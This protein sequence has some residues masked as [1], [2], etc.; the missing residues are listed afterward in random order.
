[1]TAPEEGRLSELFVRY[2]D[3]MLTGA[4]AEELG[5]HLAT[6]ASAREMFEMCCLHA[7]VAGEQPAVTSWA[8][9]PARKVT[10][11][12]AARGWSRRRVISA[13]GGS[14]AASLLAGFAGWRFWEAHSKKLVRLS[15]IVGDVSLHAANGSILPLTSLVPLGATVSTLGPVSSVV[16]SYSDG[17]GISLTGDS[18]LTVAD[19]SGQLM[20]RRGG[21][22]A[23]IASRPADAVPITVT[24]TEA[25]VGE[26]NGVRLSMGRIGNATVVS[27]QQGQVNVSAASGESLGKVSG[28]ELLTVRAHGACRKEPMPVTPDQ[29]AWTLSKPLPKDWALG[30]RMESADG[31]F[32]VPEYWFDPYH[33]ARMCQIRSDNQWNRGL[34]RVFPDSI[35]RVRYWVDR[36]APSQVSIVVR[37]KSSADP[38]SGV[39][40]YNG[41]FAR[42]RPKEWQWLEVRGD[43]LLDN[44]HRPRF[45][46]PW[47]GFL[48]IFNT[49]KEDIGLKVAEFEVRRPD[50]VAANL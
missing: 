2:W 20:L 32:V 43:E 25:T 6:D 44:I 37:T 28:G 10:V 5:R 38:V 41:A 3:N 42:S 14:V 12:P 22:T 23:N 48:V 30:Y 34:F 27:V 35:I 13:L 1:M 11:Q 39:I 18:V 33:Q 19:G 45:A 40:E 49:Y 29:F 24:T 17:A 36:P 47:V 8:D 4:E 7:V 16:L 50:N 9:L 15:Q 21:A 46:A 26:L 31:P